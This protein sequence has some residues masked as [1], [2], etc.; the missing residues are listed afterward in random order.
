MTISILYSDSHATQ[1]KLN[2]KTLY[3][4]LSKQYSNTP[5]NRQLIYAKKRAA[6]SS[7]ALPASLHIRGLEPCHFTC[8]STFLSISTVYFLW[9]CSSQTP[10]R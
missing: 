3:P 1:Q 10:S 5:N 2:T 4:Y 6:Q 8:L 7:T 9:S